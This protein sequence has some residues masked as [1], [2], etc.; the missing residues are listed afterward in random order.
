MI[1]A[2][3][4]CICSTCEFQVGGGG[5]SRSAGVK[6]IHVDTQKTVKITAQVVEIDWDLPPEPG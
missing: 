4:G 3:A 5:A 1:K 6:G 2:V